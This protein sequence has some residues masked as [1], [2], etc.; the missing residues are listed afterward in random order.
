MRGVTSR[1][2]PSPIDR[3]RIGSTLCIQFGGFDGLSF[4]YRPDLEVSY[5]KRTRRVITVYLGGRA[6]LHLRTSDGR[7]LP[8]Y[9]GAQELF[10][11]GLDRNKITIEDDAIPFVSRGRSLF[12]RHVSKAS[13]DIRPGSEVF[14]FSN[15]GKFLAV[16]V[17]LHPWYAMLELSNGVAVKIKHLIDKAQTA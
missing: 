16:G 2:S 17:S 15:S 6:A 13:P 4:A 7:F 11:S 14:V 8:T 3:L 12:N 9:F 10:T 1:C 5:S